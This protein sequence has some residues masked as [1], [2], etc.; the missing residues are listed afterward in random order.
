MKITLNGQ[1]LEFE[2]G[3]NVLDMLGALD[4]D[5]KKRALAASVEGKTVSL[6]TAIDHDCDIQVLTF[7]SDEG[8]RVLRHTASHVLAQ[9]VKRL[10]PEAKLA[11]GPAIDDGFFYDFDVE[12]PFTPEDLAKIEKEMQHIIKKNERLVRS[13][14]PRA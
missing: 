10:F 6:V 12:K 5:L 8:R 11:I 7:D 2:C 9:A 4:G 1:T 14:L 13:E 3:T